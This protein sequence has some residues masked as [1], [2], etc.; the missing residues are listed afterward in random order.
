MDAKEPRN[1]F[2]DRFSIDTVI[3]MSVVATTDV[4]LIRHGET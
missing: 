2:R 1:Y 3:E 4:W